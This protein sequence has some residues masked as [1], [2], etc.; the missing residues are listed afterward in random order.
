MIESI[1]ADQTIDV[2]AGGGDLRF[3]HHDCEIS[4]YA[5]SHHTPGRK[6]A[7][8]W[9]H[10]G[11]VLVGREK[12]AKSAGNFFTVPDVVA[13]GF[14]GPEIRL[15]LLQTHYRS[16]LDFTDATLESARLALA[17]WR[18]A[19]LPYTSLEPVNNMVSQT[20]IGALA[21]DLNTPQAITELHEATNLLNTT[22]NPTVAQG[23][24]F[25]LDRLGF[26]QKRPSASQEEQELLDQRREARKTG[27]YARSDALRDVLAGHGIRVKDMVDGTLW[28]RS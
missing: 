14:T 16:P 23:M 10:N 8:F 28:W 27:D 19:L 7:N 26:A 22:K 2:H 12:M 9:V 17:R 13:R 6:L 20:I 3:P 11:M 24:M 15:A 5:C 18:D 25:A 1:F 4:Q 21:K